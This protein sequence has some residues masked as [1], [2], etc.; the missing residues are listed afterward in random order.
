[1]K[2]E[3]FTDWTRLGHIYRWAYYPFKYATGLIMANIV[4]DSLNNKTLTEGDYCKFLSLGSSVALDKLL[5][6][7][8]IDLANE[9][10]VETGFK[11]METSLITC[12]NL[13]KDDIC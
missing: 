4:V 8:H 2:E 6:V 3:A 7:L 13:L 1:M 12:R 9:K 5:E 10:I 11:K